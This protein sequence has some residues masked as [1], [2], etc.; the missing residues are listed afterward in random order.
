MSA[1]VT[2][3][4]GLTH[5]EFFRTLPGVLAGL[6]FQRQEATVEV[7]D[8]DRHLTIHLAPEGQRR[9]AALRLPVTRVTFVFRGYAEAERAA[10]LQ[11]FERRFQ[12]GGG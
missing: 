6:R 1:V 4:M 3:D 8:A 2:R 7:F 10:F 11:H 12:R 5:A 9:L